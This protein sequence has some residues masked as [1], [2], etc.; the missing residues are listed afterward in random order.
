[1]LPQPKIVFALDETSKTAAAT[2]TALIDTLGFHHLA[3]AVKA[4]T[5]DVKKSSAIRNLLYLLRCC[6]ISSGVPT[7]QKAESTM[8]ANNTASGAAIGLPVKFASRA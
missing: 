5:A 6:K 4:G 7:D 2:A 8:N 1:M 3:L